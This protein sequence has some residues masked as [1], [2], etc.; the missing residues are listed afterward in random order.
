VD[1]VFMQTSL[2]KSLHEIVDYERVNERLMRGDNPALREHLGMI[3]AVGIQDGDSET[4][5]DESEEGSEDEGED[6]EGA[7]KEWVERPAKNADT[8]RA[9]SKEDRRA[10]KERVKEEAREKRKAKIKK[11]VKKKFKKQAAAGNR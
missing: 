4:E 6:G 3:G 11:H 2:P 7:E 10:H 9:Q 5:D 8:L 1:A